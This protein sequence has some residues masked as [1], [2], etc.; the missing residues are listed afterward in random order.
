[1]VVVLLDRGERAVGRLAIIVNSDGGD[2]ADSSW[3]LT[4][5]GIPFIPGSFGVASGRGDSQGEGDGDTSLA[6][7]NGVAV[8][9]VAELADRRTE[10]RIISTSGSNTTPKFSG[11]AERKSEGAR[12]SS[13]LGLSSTMPARGSCS[14]TDSA[15]GRSWGS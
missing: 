15:L 10:E 1:M 14:I 12:W 7:T 3:P 9:N 8:L 6:L 4:P 11:P 5:S 13:P 2:W